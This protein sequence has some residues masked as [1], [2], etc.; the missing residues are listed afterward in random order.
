MI[1]GNAQDSLLLNPS[2][3]LED[4]GLHRAQAKGSAPRMAEIT[5]TPHSIQICFQVRQL[6]ACQ[7][8]GRSRAGRDAVCGAKRVLEG[9]QGAGLGIGRDE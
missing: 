9:C 1:L 5:A 8:G 2:C 6:L 4:S 7:P 3:Y